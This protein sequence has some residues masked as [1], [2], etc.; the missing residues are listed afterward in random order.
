MKLRVRIFLLCAFVPRSMFSFAKRFRGLLVRI[1]KHL[2]G[3]K[4]ITTSI[5]F[6]K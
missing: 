6:M 5:S 3:D 4:Q 2:S 1:H